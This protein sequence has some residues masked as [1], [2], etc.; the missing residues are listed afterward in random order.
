MLTQLEVR[1]YDLGNPSYDARTVLTVKALDEDDNEPAFSRSKYPVPYHMQAV[2]ESTDVVSV[3][4]VAL[5]DDADSGNNSAICYYL[6]GEYT[7]DHSCHH[8]E[9]CSWNKS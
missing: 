3:G 6:V 9:L 1:A 5:A 8:G 4:S 7:I 2:E